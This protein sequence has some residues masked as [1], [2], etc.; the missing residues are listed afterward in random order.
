M[1]LVYV[2]GFAAVGFDRNGHQQAA[3]KMPPIFEDVLDTTSGA[4][5]TAALPNTV[6]L[7]RIHTDGAVNISIKAGA[8]AADGGAASPSQSSVPM[9]A[10]TTEYFTVDPEA[11]ARVSAITNA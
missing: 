4:D 7:L 6:S 5:N 3:P 11:G 2:A 1:A 9:A 8:V 10:N